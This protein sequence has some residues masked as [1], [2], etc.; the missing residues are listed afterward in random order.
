MFS[1][2]AQRFESTRFRSPYPEG[3]TWQPGLNEP[4]PQQF[5]I[6]PIQRPPSRYE[7]YN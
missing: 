7:C 6:S 3:P 1:I 2:A 4:H 5:L